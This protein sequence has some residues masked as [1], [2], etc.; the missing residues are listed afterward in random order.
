MN[1][2]NPKSPKSHMDQLHPKN[3]KNLKDQKSL[4][5]KQTNLSTSVAQKMAVGGALLMIK[6]VL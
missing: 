5:Q 6:A 4:S 3:P 2:T 1:P